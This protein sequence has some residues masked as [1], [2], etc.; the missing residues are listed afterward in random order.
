M[1]TITRV[2]YSVHIAPKA[3]RQLQKVPRQIVDK[4][5][6]WVQ[7]VELE[8][9]EKV[10]RI[11]G[12]HDEALKGQRSGQRSIRL[13]KAYRAIYELKK[14]RCLFFASI[15]EVTKHEY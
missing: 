10:R 7:A 1:G 2:I 13:N 15:E 3:A 12:Y 8:G 14:E 6:T 9:L 4:L 11:L 5:E